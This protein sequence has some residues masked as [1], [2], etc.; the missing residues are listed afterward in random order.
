M[1]R[2]LEGNW[3]SIH[4]VNSERVLKLE[5]FPRYRFKILKASEW[6]NECSIRVSGY[7]WSESCKATFCRSKEQ[8]TAWAEGFLQCQCLRGQCCQNSA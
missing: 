6:F 8:D 4:F 5:K 7:A 3:N 1:K 2:N